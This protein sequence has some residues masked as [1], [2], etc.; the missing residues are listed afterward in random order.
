[1][2]QFVA[3]LMAVLIVIGLAACGSSG[4]SAAPTEPEGSA[5]DAAEPSQD[6][7]TDEAASEDA[8]DTGALQDAFKEKIGGSG[9]TFYKSVPNDVTGNWRVAVIYTDADMVENALDYYNAY[10]GSDDEI[11]FVCNL[12]LKTTTSI[13]VLAGQL[14]VD[15]FEYVDGEEHDAKTLPGGDLLKSYTVDMT[16]G[17]ATEL[18]D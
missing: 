1:M 17:D 16:T 8:V 14:F 4:E 9:L 15:V 18:S 12:G 6:V 13:K 2:K 11:H 3:L 7:Q 5:Q 10:F